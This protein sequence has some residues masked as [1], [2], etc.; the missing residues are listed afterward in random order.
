MCLLYWVLIKYYWNLLFLCYTKIWI[1]VK[2]AS[3]FSPVIFNVTIL[4][5]KKWVN[6]CQPINEK[7]IFWSTYY[8]KF[9]R[10]LFPPVTFSITRPSNLL[11]F[12]TFSVFRSNK[13]IFRTK[14]FYLKV[15][16]FPMWFKKIVKIMQ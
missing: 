6:K 12:V 5:W 2:K 8:K 15:M 14:L 9:P 1:Q 16:V 3:T 13:T 10:N 11:I 7:V 4:L